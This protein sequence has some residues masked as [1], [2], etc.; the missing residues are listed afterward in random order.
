MKKIYKIEV[1]MFPNNELDSSKPF[2]W[3]IMSNT[4]KDWCNETAGWESTPEKAWEE[5][6]RFYRKYKADEV[7]K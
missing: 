7:T 4:G 3:C 6:I 1:M 5:A 2:F